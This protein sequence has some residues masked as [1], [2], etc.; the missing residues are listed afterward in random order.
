MQWVPS[1][2]V[3]LGKPTIG[4][5]FAQVANNIETKAQRKA[6][7]SKILRGGVLAFKA[8]SF[9]LVSLIEKHQ[10]LLR[11]LHYLESIE[12]IENES[13]EVQKTKYANGDILPLDWLNIK[14][15]HL[16]GGEPYR[17]RI[18]EIELLEI[19]IRKTAKY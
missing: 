10:M 9:S 2:G 16:R 15:E 8:D 3:T 18:E 4:F 19:E 17:K 13:F 5:S 7:K 6:E 12:R 11:S 14:A 1:F